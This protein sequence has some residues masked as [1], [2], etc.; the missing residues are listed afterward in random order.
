MPDRNDIVEIQLFNNL[1]GISDH[2]IPVLRFPFFAAAMPSLVDTDGM[3]V[4]SGV[5]VLVPNSRVKAGG[6]HEE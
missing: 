3:K 1:S 5:D 4:A 2:F 6:V